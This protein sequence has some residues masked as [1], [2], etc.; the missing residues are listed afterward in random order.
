MLT[1]LQTDLGSIA[2][3]AQYLQSPINDEGAMIKRE[4]LRYADASLSSDMPA[5]EMIIQSWDT[6]I[7]MGANNDRSACITISYVSG[8]YTVIDALAVRADFPQL[9][10]VVLT[11]YEKF[12]PHA[13]LIEDKAS[14]QSLIQ[15]LRTCSDLPIIAIMPKGDKLQ[16]VA[17]ITPLMEAGRVQMLSQIGAAHFA[18]LEAEMLGFPS[19]KHDDMVDALTQGLQWLQQQFQ[20]GVHRLRIL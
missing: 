13:V 20:T 10:A 11:Q 2:F 8:N 5:P 7:K 16:R 9:R 12:K 18:E 3:A 6:A 14:G 17:R 19:S 4:W 1:Q 15:E